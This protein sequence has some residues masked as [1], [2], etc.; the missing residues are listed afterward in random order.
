[1]LQNRAFQQVTPGIS[2]LFHHHKVNLNLPPGT[3]AALNAWQAVNGGAIS[4]I[5]ETVPVS[6]ALPNA[7]HLTIP[8]GR[9]GAVGF[10]NTG[11][12]GASAI[13]SSKPSE[14]K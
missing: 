7:L 3:T 2:R 4:V 8:S 14:L 13:P 1:M 9:T 6:S 10:A 5:K 11:F 12:F